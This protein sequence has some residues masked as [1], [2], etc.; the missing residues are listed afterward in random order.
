VLK[1]WKQLGKLN[2]NQFIV[3]TIVTTE[4]LKDI[5]NQ[6]GVECFDVLTGFKYIAEKIK[7][8]DGKKQFLCGG[9][10]SYGYS[11]GDFVRDKDAVVSS[12]I[13]AEIA[14]WAKEQGKSLYDILID[15]YLEFGYYKESLLSITKKGING[16]LEIKQ[17][18]ENYRLNPPATINSKKIIRIKDYK[19]LQD[20]NL[21]TGEM[22]KITL[23]VSDVLQFYLEDN[24]KITMRPSGTEPKIKFY[25]SVKTELKDKSSLTQTTKILDER[26]KRIVGDMFR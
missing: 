16:T 23:P 9:E 17:M 26:I 19:T 13:I 1:Q 18:M 4:L 3:K 25:F 2:G 6:Y 20:R 24:S 14:A 12:C 8:W 11:V 7:E 22:E 10:E 15:I 21:V 5:A